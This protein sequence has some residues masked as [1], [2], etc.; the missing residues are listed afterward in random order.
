MLIFLFA[1]DELSFDRFHTKKDQLY[2]ITADITNTRG[3]I[4][5]LGSTG[6]MPG[7]AF[8]EQIPEIGEFVRLESAYCNVKMG[9]S[10]FEQE[11]LWVD[12]N[13]FSV[14]SFPLVSGDPATALTDPHFVVISEDVAEKYFGKNNAIGKILQLNP[15]KQFEPFVVSGVAKNSPQNSSIKVKL[16]LPMKLHQ[17]QQDDKQWMNFFLNTFVVIKPGTDLPATIK[18]FNSVYLAQAHDQIRE[19]KEKFDYQDK[20]TYGLQP[21][22]EMHLSKDYPADNGMSNASDPTY[23]IILTGIALFILIIACINFINLTVSRSIRRAK[24]IGI[25]KVVG[26][27]KKQITLQ[28]LGESF[29]LSFFSFLIAVILVVISLPFFNSVSEKALSFSYLLDAKLVGGYFMLFIVTSLMAGFYPALVLSKFNPVQTVYARA[30]A[31]GKNYLSKGLVIFQFT[32]STFLIIATIIIYSQFNYLINYNI[33]YDKTDVVRVNTGKMNKSRLQALKNTLTSNPAIKMV[34]AEQGGGYRTVAHIN[35][36]QSIE[37]GYHFIDEQNFPMFKIP[38]IEGRNYSTDFPSDSSKSIM[39]N[40]AF[41]KAAGWKKPLGEIINFYYNNKKYAVIGVVRDF[42]T[43]PLTVT[44]TPEVFSMDP[45]LSYQSVFMKLSPGGKTAALA[46]IEKTF[47]NMFPTQPYKYS[48]IEDDLLS[49]YSSEAKWK[50][51]ITFSALLTVF[52]SCIG[53]FGLAALSA[54]K[55]AKEIGIRKVLGASVAG[56]AKKLSRDF[57]KLVFIG[58]FIAIPAAYWAMKRWLEN[59]PFR[60]DLHP[61]VFGIAAIL[62]LVIALITVIYQAIKAAMANPVTNLRSE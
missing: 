20:V 6:M 8:K 16:L 42:N 48:F 55:R 36:E 28:F 62:V 45:G 37:F 14:F 49:Q 58:T 24:E 3:E 11:A 1:K 35:G 57:I 15:G 31:G 9:T 12:E 51:I 61:S 2:R 22:Q 17:A 25:R 33:G 41:V 13:F 44:I 50:Q 29:L 19:M 60:I 53:L 27:Q 26:G 38:V 56:I 10:V 40:E 54:E 30:Q 52:I 32:L 43:G 4:S 23:S 34:T 7:P 5:H 59:Y 21:F 18:K 39:V 47:K 46:H